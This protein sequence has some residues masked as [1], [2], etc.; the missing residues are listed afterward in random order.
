[1]NTSCEAKSSRSRHRG[2]G[3]DAWGT[4]PG[5]P[6]SF[7]RY[8]SYTS[9][10]WDISPCVGHGHWEWNDEGEGELVVEPA[11]YPSERRHP[12]ERGCWFNHQTYKVY[13][14]RG[15]LDLFLEMGSESRDYSGVIRLLLTRG[16]MRI[17]TL[18]PFFL[19]FY[20]YPS[21]LQLQRALQVS[22]APRPSR[23]RRETGLLRLPRRL[24]IYSL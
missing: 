7:I 6:S 4:F 18:S 22:H 2:R 5:R 13:K 11:P 9:N 23:L 1:M 24:D 16:L 17:P 15:S 21:L 3:S 8:I 19:P 20:I 12:C 10:A 14:V